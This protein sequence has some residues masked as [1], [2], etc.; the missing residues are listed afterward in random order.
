[1]NFIWDKENSEANLKKHHAS[2]DVTARIFLDEKR[3]E[4]YDEKHSTVSEDR[5]I[6]IGYVDNVSL[7]VVYE[8]MNEKM[9]RI[10]S[11]RK[12][13]KHERERIARY[14]L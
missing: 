11:A 14:S 13:T 3:V 12:A 9:A 5:Y 8:M 2:F 6:T 10:T 1:M 4:I 7:F